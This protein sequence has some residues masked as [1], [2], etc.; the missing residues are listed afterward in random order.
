MIIATRLLKLRD[1]PGVEIPINI[2]APEWDGA[3]W[4][5]RWEIHW[6]DHQRN[7]AATGVD[8]VQALFLALQMIGADIY[9]SDY[10]KSGEL[11]WKIPARGYGFPVPRNLRDLLVGDDEVYG[12]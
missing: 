6:P 1:Q 7:M 5:C 8:S 11:V 10:H 4:S 12:A 2:F 9:T 3:S